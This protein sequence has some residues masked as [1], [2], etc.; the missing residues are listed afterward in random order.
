M[1]DDGAL[2]WNR[3]WWLW[4]IPCF[5]SGIPWTILSSSLSSRG[6]RHTFHRIA[7]CFMDLLC[8]RGNA[9]ILFVA[10]CICP[11]R[12][13][14]AS[15]LPQSELVGLHSGIVRPT[16][17]SGFVS[18]DDGLPLGC[19]KFTY[20]KWL[21]FPCSPISLLVIGNI[22]VVLPPSPRLPCMPL[23]SSLYICCS[24]WTDCCFAFLGYSWF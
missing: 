19:W 10:R 3:Y 14:R 24:S 23:P 13:G 7:Q 15:H 9:L 12:M 17:Q 18:G 1:Y 5:R 2:G 6:S 4:A 22:F 16:Q 21:H 20:K 8:N 11:P